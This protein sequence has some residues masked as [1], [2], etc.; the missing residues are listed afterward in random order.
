MQK[1]DSYTDVT[2]RSKSA[3]RKCGRR[4]V[5]HH[6][7][8]EGHISGIEYHIYPHIVNYNYNFRGKRISGYNIFC[9]ISDAF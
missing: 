6:D 8:V 3:K 4:S 7:E 2:D 1:G 9:Y 5:V